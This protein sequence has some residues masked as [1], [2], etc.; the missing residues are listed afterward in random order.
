MR[1]NFAQVHPPL[2]G[3][4]ILHDTSRNGRCYSCTLQHFS[5]Y[6]CAE[7][8]GPPRSL[9]ISSMPTFLLIRISYRRVV[10]HLQF[11]PFCQSAQPV[12]NIH[13]LSLVVPICCLIYLL[14]IWKGALKFAEGSVEADLQ[15]SHV[16]RSRSRQVATIGMFANS[17]QRLSDHF[18]RS[19]VLLVVLDK[20]RLMSSSPVSS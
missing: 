8:A 15:R 9:H 16:D 4:S 17:Y 6:R 1:A 13:L 11:A 18:Y 10:C 7:I 2:D 14:K 20:V 12:S 5:L 3:A 19:A